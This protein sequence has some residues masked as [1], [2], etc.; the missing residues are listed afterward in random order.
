MCK[1]SIIVPVYNKK[2]Y[3]DSVLENIQQQE[4]DDFEC[5]LVDDGST[6]GSQSICNSFSEKDDRFITIH[7]PNAGVS[8]A[9]NTGLIK[10]KGKYITFIDADDTIDLDYLK[11][12][13]DDI[14]ITNVDLVI[15]SMKKTWD[16][17]SRS[18]YYKTPYIG[19]QYFQ[20][21]IHD[22]CK[23]QYSSGLYGYCCGKIF[24]KELA[25]NI[26]FDPSINLAEDFDFY[27]KLYKRVE[28]IYFDPNC[29]YGYLQESINN[30]VK[31]DNKIDYLVQLK[32]NLNTRKF[33]ISK[34][35]YNQNNRKIIDTKIND[36]IYFVIL[37][38]NR[39]DIKHKMTELYKL[40]NTKDII[41]DSSL[42]LK[43]IVLV[44]I[45]FKRV[46]SIKF[47]LYTYDFLRRFRRR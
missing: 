2:E 22:F 27:L 7:Q 24:R 12:L 38:S 6:D 36:Y 13:V 28:K 32:I 8:N 5:I 34:S 40:I 44:L 10:A 29:F 35:C 20:D 3:L 11:K 31:D 15:A 4:F 23:I 33:L 1:V 18:E 39:K 42:S 9:R 16:K 43:N 37:Y 46:N 17:S 14:E 25:K 41:I 19:T 26:F 47:V 21:I 30:S 45:K